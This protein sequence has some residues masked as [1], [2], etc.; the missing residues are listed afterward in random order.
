MSNCLTPL[1]QSLFA[2]AVWL[3]TAGAG[4]AASALPEPIGTAPEVRA[5][6]Y[7]PLEKG[8]ERTVLTD[9]KILATLVLFRTQS[10]QLTYTAMLNYPYC[11]GGSATLALRG[12]SRQHDT[13]SRPIRKSDQNRDFN[14]TIADAMCK[15]YVASQAAP[16]TT[17]TPS[18]PAAR[19][20]PFH[21]Q[22][23][24]EA[25]L[26]R[27]YGTSR[28]TYDA[29]GRVEGNHVIADVTG[30]V[31]AD[32]HATR[33]TYQIPQALCQTGT[34]T[35]RVTDGKRGWVDAVTVR[36][37]QPVPH[38]PA[39]ELTAKIVDGI[40]LQASGVSMVP[41]QVAATAPGGATR[42]TSSTHVGTRSAKP[43]P[44]T[45]TLEQC[46]DAWLDAFNEERGEEGPIPMGQME[47]WED[48]CR[49]GKTPT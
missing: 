49:A 14:H 21:H 9:G 40:C 29:S 38:S 17:S 45:Q 6:L 4:S 5:N 37:G 19:F 8:P 16:A 32:G 43:A 33:L 15:D 3:A 36:N 1:N 39:N 34:G 25:R 10:S 20:T 41:D 7:F 13:R 46:T 42:T 44:G 47:E 48:W 18:R 11:S 2:C 12:E 28:V 30:T 26:T 22:R 23:L 35:A 27:N 31:V 24:F